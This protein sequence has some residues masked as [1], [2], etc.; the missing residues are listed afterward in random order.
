MRLHVG[1]LEIGHNGS[2]SSCGLWNED[3]FCNKCYEY[4]E[5]PKL[6]V[7]KKGDLLADS[8]EALVNAVNTVGV[9]G[10]G[11]ARQFKKQFPEMFIEYEQACRANEVTLGKMH[12]VKVPTGEDHQYIINFPTLAH[13]SD[14]SELKH[15]EA[16]LVDLVRV[17][18][19][20]KIKSIAIPPL[21]CGVG[22]LAWEDV[23]GLIEEAFCHVTG[24]QVHLYKPL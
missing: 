5:V 9:M 17:V 2:E 18:Q 12:V 11:I 14:Q 4:R 13:W 6:I 10:A 16:G 21:G 8:A 19:E 23:R 1:D 24:V 15:I 22:G 7:Y 20:K 3:S